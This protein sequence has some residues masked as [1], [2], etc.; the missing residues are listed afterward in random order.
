MFP[1]FLFFPHGV[2]STREDQFFLAFGLGSVHPIGKMKITR[3]AIGRFAPV[4]ERGKAG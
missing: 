3:W 1:F 4:C 2:L